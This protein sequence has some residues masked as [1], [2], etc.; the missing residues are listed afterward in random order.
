MTDENR[1]AT[2]SVYQAA[3]ADTTPA[4]RTRLL[5]E[6]LAESCIYADPGGIWEGRKAIT[7]KIARFRSDMPGTVFRNHAFLFHHGWSL[8]HWTLFDAS[9]DAMVSGASAA[10]YGSD[11]RIMR[12]TGFFPVATPSCST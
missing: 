1:A 11:G 8:A 2:W 5:E 3:W 9:G 4:E 6:S 7:G 10:E 12:V